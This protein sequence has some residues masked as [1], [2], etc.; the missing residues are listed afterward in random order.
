[1]I[2]L[3]QAFDNA[4]KRA[5]SSC[6]RKFDLQNSKHKYQM[7]GPRMVAPS[8]YISRDVAVKQHVTLADGHT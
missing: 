1:M 8:K 6:K 3:H 7:D 4:N 2:F 5:L